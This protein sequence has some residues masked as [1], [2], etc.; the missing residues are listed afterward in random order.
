MH[1]AQWSRQGKRAGN[2]VDTVRNQKDAPLVADFFD[3][4][5]CYRELNWFT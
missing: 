2:F 4:G 3:L 1:N 5:L